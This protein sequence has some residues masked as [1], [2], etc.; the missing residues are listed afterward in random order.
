M[1]FGS[2]FP[3]SSD[4]LKDHRTGQIEFLQSIDGPR[5]FSK[6]IVCYY[7]DPRLGGVSPEIASPFCPTVIA[8]DDVDPALLFPSGEHQ[9]NFDFDPD[10]IHV[11]QFPGLFSLVFI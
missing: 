2:I 3:H 7:D 8:T 1:F 9:H 11:F 4:S 6:D 5:L 10:I